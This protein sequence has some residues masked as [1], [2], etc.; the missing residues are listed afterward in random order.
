[1]KLNLLKHKPEPT[2]IIAIVFSLLGVI[3]NKTTGAQELAID[4]GRADEVHVIEDN[5]VKLRVNFNFSGITAFG[6]ETAIGTFDEIG[7]SGAYSIGELGQPNLPASKSLIEIP[8]GADISVSYTAGSVT[9]YRL[10]DYNITQPLLP[11]QPSIRKDQNV[12]D[13]PF[14]FDPTIYQTDAFIEHEP[15]FVEIL[16]VMRGIR[17][18]RLTVA[19]VSYN[20]V[21]GI[22]R[23]MNDIE[24]E[25]RFRNV[26]KALNENIKASTFSPYFEVVQNS[27][28]NDLRNGYPNHPDLTKY[29]VKYL[30]VS[31]RMFEN[32]LQPFIQWKTQKGFKV[33]TGYT[34]QIGSTYA[35][36]Q[37]WVHN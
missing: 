3:L 4:F 2:F 11:V 9:E 30:I 20:P 34:D 14:E 37:S 5:T 6:V 10:S 24:V 31:P 18:A 7:M 15:A 26:D 23:I 28:L 22:I 36:I 21:Q 33:I 12:E 27:L 19:P 29:P 32:D 13:V 25:V 35:A 17:I 1:M 16:G 8:H